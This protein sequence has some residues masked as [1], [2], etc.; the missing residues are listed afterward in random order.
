MN[1]RIVT[2]LF[3]IA[4]AAALVGG[5][6][7]AWFTSTASVEGNEF[8]AGTLK[9]E[10]DGENVSIDEEGVITFNFGNVG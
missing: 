1:K 6:T 10:V 9:F 2:S 3:V 7:M 5:A 4:L 8:T